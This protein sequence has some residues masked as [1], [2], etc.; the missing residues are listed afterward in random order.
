MLDVDARLLSPISGSSGGWGSELTASLIM[1]RE[2]RFES[3][4]CRAFS[5]LYL[6]LLLR[7]ESS[8]EYTAV[9]VW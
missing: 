2:L 9:L 3:L 4:P 7:K 6:T 8:M 1:L 5:I